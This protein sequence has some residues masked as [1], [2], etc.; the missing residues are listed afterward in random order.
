MF[1][2]L[3]YI[4]VINLFVVVAFV[5]GCSTNVKLTPKVSENQKLIFQDGREALVSEKKHV[6]TIA[7]LETFFKHSGRA[8]FIVAIKNQ[9]K[10][11]LLFSTANLSAKYNCRSLLYVS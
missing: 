11:D 2:Y 8:K 10:D 6:V 9:M 1:K 4:S 3:N 5:S 7:P